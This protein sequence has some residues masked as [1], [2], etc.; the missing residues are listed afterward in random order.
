MASPLD[1]F[2][3]AAD[4]I[5][6]GFFRLFSDGGNFS[7]EELEGFMKQLQKEN[8]RI[9]FVEGL[10]MIDMEKAETGYLEQVSL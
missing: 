4:P 5:P 7:P 2:P 1:E 3:P 10:I 9:E 8:S 6:G